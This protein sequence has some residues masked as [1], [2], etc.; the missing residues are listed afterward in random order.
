MRVLLVNSVL[1]LCYLSTYLSTI[2]STELSVHR[3]LCLNSFWFHWGR[4]QQGF[5]LVHE[6]FADGFPRSKR[7][8]YLC[9]YVVTSLMYEN[10]VWVAIVSLHRALFLTALYVLSHVSCRI[11]VLLLEEPKNAHLFRHSFSTCSFQSQKC[12][13]C[14]WF[15]DEHRE[16]LEYRNKV[17]RAYPRWNK[18]QAQRLDRFFTTSSASYTAW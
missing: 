18:I 13:S 15:E 5:C 16:N 3:S 6:D 2:I 17:P 7:C 12:L 8:S 9:R 10:R 11:F 4:A 14:F 1:K